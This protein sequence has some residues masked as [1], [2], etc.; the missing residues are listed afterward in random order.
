MAKK[1]KLPNSKSPDTPVIEP[2]AIEPSELPK[3][4][5]WID[6]LADSGL[7]RERRAIKASDKG[8]NVTID[9]KPYRHVSDHADG[10]WQFALDN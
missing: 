9:G 7:V 5:V 6:V 1:L 10:S 4:H 8:F 3:D 2:L